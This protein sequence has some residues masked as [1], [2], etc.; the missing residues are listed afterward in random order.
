MTPQQR[1][2]GTQAQ[3]G[4]AAACDEVTAAHHGQRQQGR[5]GW[6]SEGGQGVQWSP[7]RDVGY[8]VRR[9]GW[10]MEVVTRLGQRGG[11]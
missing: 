10:A 3:H 6:A 9:R 2:L 4:V 7:G 5:Q 8:G 1:C 11:D